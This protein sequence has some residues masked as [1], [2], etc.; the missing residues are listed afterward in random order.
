MVTDAVLP[1]GRS[2]S[3]SLL[4]EGDDRD[5]SFEHC[6]AR[7]S[8]DS[9]KWA[10]YGPDVLP[11]WVADMD[12]QAPK[13]VL[14]AL[15]ERVTHGVFGY[16]QEPKELAERVVARLER[17]FDWRIEPDD[18]VFIPGVMPG[19]NLAC[20]ITTQPGDAVVIQT[21]VY[22]PIRRLPGELE[23]RRVELDFAKDMSGRA[24]IDWSDFARTLDDSARL[25]V[26]CN[27]QNPTGR[28][29]ERGE[30]EQMAEQC[31]RRH[32]YI[33]S[34]EIHA[35]LVHSG[36]RHI[37]IAS[38]SREVADRTITLMAPSKTYNLA[39]LGCAFAIIQNRELRTRFRKARGSLVPHVDIL[40]YTAAIAAYRH[41]D[42]WL[43][44][45]REQ[46]LDNRRRVTEFVAAHLPGVDCV[47]PEGTYLAWLDCGRA[48]LPRRPFDFFLN[49]AKVALN[50]GGLFG[51]N[52]DYHIRLNFGCSEST[53]LEALGRMQRALQRHHAEQDIQLPNTSD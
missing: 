25:F 36:H 8:G 28:V 6:P 24:T 45:I 30:L 27:P 18:I 41:G 26:L 14:R 31:L 50:D 37:P 51:R 39:G 12:V 53:L 46:L 7:R 23:R 48:H 44:R 2:T 34:D 10:F 15:L 49:E 4:E 40:A 35:D 47:A 13:A 1:E 29:F 42:A 3:S 32:V 22:P 5:G 43:S 38:L 20:T 19:A 21:P 9:V 33:C 16:G 11:L 52:S 17:H